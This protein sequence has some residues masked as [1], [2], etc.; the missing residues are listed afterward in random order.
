[1]IQVACPEDHDLLPL[2]SDEAVSDEVRGHLDG[3]S[4]CRSRLAMLK[5][6]VASLRGSVE[7]GMGPAAFSPVPDHLDETKDADSLD[8]QCPDVSPSP[9]SAAGPPA[10]IGRYLVVGVLDTG[11][12]ADVYRVVHPT[13]SKELVLKLS[14]RAC[15][16]DRAD[17]DQFVV[18]GKVL[19]DLEHPNMVR[20]FDLDFHEDHPFLVMEFVRGRNLQQAA[21]Q[22]RPVPRQA[23][24]WVAQV[25]RAVALVHSRGIVH[26]DIKPKNILIDE[27][28][29]ARLIDFGLAHWRHAWAEDAVPSG[30]G[31]LAYMAPEQAR[32]ERARIGPR[33]D[34]FGLGGVLYFLLTGQA[35]YRGQSKAEVWGHAVRC[36]YDATALRGPAIPRGLAQIC[37]RAMAPEPEGRYASAEELADDLERFLR[38]P[39]RLLAGAA[40]ALLLPLGYVAWSLA[41]RPAT[42]TVPL[43]IAAMQV[44]LHRR[45][46]PEDLGAI[47]STV[48]AGRLDD[49]VRVHARLT[50]PAYCYLIALNPD[51]KP[52]LCVPGDESTSPQRSSEVNFPPDPTDGFGLTDGVGLQAFVLFASRDPLPPYRDW[53]AHLGG[54]PWHATV[55]DRGWRFEG[56]EFTPLTR[57]IENAVDR[58]SVRKLTDLP[59]PFAAVCR[60]IKSSPGTTS[61]QALA[62]PVQPKE[63]AR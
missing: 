2:V 59:G 60:A 28:G 54:L 32:D 49:D 34:I 38:R 1:M 11:G 19:A 55:A 35:P 40:V 39:R 7:A 33:S 14:K 17:R 22:Q 46:P 37:L 25:A 61:I 47:G 21:S 45:N 52:Q 31:T 30:G 57:F 12:Q 6:E 42:P 62:F 58:G 41:P 20:I 23:A 13:L 10:A 3:C 18:E 50:A 9:A 5:A 27:S 15:V 48:F 24:A 51:G 26:Q 4:E 16:R 43:K 44:D 8:F 36:D 63:P 56:G 29:R 53:L